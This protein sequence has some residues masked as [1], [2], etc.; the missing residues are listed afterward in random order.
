LGV[1][2]CVRVYREISPARVS[3]LAYWHDQGDGGGYP[4]HG[5]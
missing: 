3:A 5:V 1:K 4:L 2:A